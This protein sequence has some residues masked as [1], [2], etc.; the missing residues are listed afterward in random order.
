MAPYIQEG[1]RVCGHRIGEVQR[2][3]FGA[4]VAQGRQRIG[5]ICVKCG[6]R[7]GARGWNK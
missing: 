5:M 6:A 4:L 2:T 3:K 7:Y 1:I